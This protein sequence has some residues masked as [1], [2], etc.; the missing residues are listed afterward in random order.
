MKSMKSVKPVQLNLGSK[1]KFRCYPGIK[2]FTKCC[3]KIDIVLTPYDIVRIKH[4]LGIGSGDFLNKYT[5]EEI[6]EKSGLPIVFL[7]MGADEE[8]LCP[9]VTPEGCTIYSDR[10]AAC[11]YYPLG[12]GTLQTEKGVEEFYFMVKEPYCCGF[13]EDVDWTVESWR[14]DQEP[15]LYDDMNREWKS[16]MLRRD[17][18]AKKA[19]DKKK[20]AMFFLASYDMDN[21]RRFVFNSR[22]LEVFTVEP[23]VLAAMEK[24]DVALMK[25]GFRYLKHLLLIEESLKAK[26]AP[27]ASQPAN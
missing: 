20:Q 9:F 26:E 10:P 16:M 22:F 13:E 21:F 12:Q 1:F 19:I 15:A 4:R 3:G 25:F 11:R 23:E 27:A 2:C 6:D 14:V 8:R 24:D 5:R 18:D 7:K 17:A